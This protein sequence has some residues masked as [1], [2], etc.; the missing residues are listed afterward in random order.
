MSLEEGEEGQPFFFFVL[1]KL[2]AEFNMEKT[3]SSY[4]GNMRACQARDASSILADRMV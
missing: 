1:I 4:S 2:A 3:R